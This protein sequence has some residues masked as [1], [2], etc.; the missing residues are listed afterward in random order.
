M[1]LIPAVDLRSGQVVQ[2]GA[3][4]RHGYPLLR[5][6]LCASAEPVAVVGAL[7]RL[8]AFPIIYLAD[9]DALQGRTAVLDPVLLARRFPCTAFW[10]DAGQHGL[11]AVRQRWH[12]LCPVYGSETGMGPRE[13]GALPHAAILSLDFRNDR[14]MGDRA[15]LATPG[16]WPPRVILMDLD[17]TGRA[18]GPNRQRAA[19][20]RRACGPSRRLYVAG[21]VRHSGDLRNLAALGVD[22]ALC[23]TALHA[24]RLPASLLHRLAECS[25]R[26]PLCRI[27]GG[28]LP[29]VGG[30]HG[31]AKPCLRRRRR[32]APRC[33]GDS[34]HL[35][36]KA[37]APRHS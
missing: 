9:L 27:R 13:L 10:L 25:Q 36:Q 1:H 30:N 26:R 35:Q 28:S 18:R 11:G 7:L 33:S 2:A 15:L 20:L 22:G 23:A 34:A 31:E 32:G 19:R 5:S 24:G 6:R 14:F 37:C 8:Y 3:G 12:N 21:G 4:P 17:R 16:R 29:A